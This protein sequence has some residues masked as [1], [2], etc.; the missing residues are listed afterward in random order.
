MIVEQAERCKVI[1][2]GL[3]NFARK[4]QVNYREVDIHELV[5]LSISSVILPANVT[6]EVIT[7]IRDP[8]GEMDKEQMIQVVS[9]LIKNGI[10]AMPGGGTINNFGWIMTRRS[11]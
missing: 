6:I 3:L 9:N 1:V 4:N 2:G 10:E 7:K 11:S 5:R 8:F